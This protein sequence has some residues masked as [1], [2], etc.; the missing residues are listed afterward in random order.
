MRHAPHMDGLLLLTFSPRLTQVELRFGLPQGEKMDLTLF[1]V[2]SG[3]CIEVL[4][5]GY[6][7]SRDMTDAG[8]M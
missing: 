7:H 4:R 5:P 3:A 1:L 6:A 2:A 8:G